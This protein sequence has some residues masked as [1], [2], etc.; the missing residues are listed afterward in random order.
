MEVDITPTL[1]TEWLRLNTS[2]RPLRQS[3]VKKYAE[4][5]AAGRFLPSPDAI[6]FARCSDGSS[7]LINGQHRLQAC[8]LAGSPFKAHVIFDMPEESF[9]ITDRGMGRSLSDVA[10]QVGLRDSKVSGG[11]LV[12]LWRMLNGKERKFETPSESEYLSIAREHQDIQFHAAT[13]RRISKLGAL[14]D[15]LATALVYRSRMISEDDSELFWGAYESGSGLS[16]NNPVLMLRNRLA[17]LKGAKQRTHAWELTALAVKA[18]N[19]FRAGSYV[20]VLKWGRD[21]PVP[22]MR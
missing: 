5:M 18:W 9:S 12:H 11:A 21:E 19:A 22:Q 14:S 10:H 17:V 8:I 16:E 2:N 15:S 6:A 7:R 4:D 13:G 3:R 1:A 20:K